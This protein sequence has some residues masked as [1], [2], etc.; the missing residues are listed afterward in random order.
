MNAKSFP[1]AT[2]E[3]ARSLDIHILQSRGAFSEPETADLQ[4]DGALLEDQ[5]RNSITVKFHGD[6]GRRD[7]I[8]LHHRRLTDGTQ[9]NE[10]IRVVATRCNYGGERWWFVCPSPSGEKECGRR[11][12]LLYSPLGATRFACRQCHN[13]TYESTRKSGGSGYER[14]ERPLKKYD[15]I[16][17][18][19]KGARGGRRRRLWERLSA[20]QKAL[21]DGFAQMPGA[22]VLGSALVLERPDL[23]PDKAHEVLLSAFSESHPEFPKKMIRS[24]LNSM[25][26]SK[27][28]SKVF[29]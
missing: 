10:R 21:E 1:K 20:A 16:I 12:R 22:S 8:S 19:L 28:K 6:P 9:C 2:V 26:Y 23:W 5:S 15:Q 7:A 25:G 17:S 29:R 24:Y 3:T 14:I 4:V 13:L 27:K 11:C 18:Q